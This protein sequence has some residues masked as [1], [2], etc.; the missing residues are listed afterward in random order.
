MSK[1]EMTLYEA[2]AKKKILESKV[3]KLRNY[4][5]VTEKKKADNTMIDGVPIE[6]VTEDIKGGYASTVAIMNNYI[7]LKAAINDANARTMVTIAG[8]EYSIANAIARHR[9]LYDEERMY[10]VIINDYVN[11]EKN[12]KD[13]NDRN[14]SPDAIST[15]IS[16][17]L[18]DSSKKNADVIEQM[19]KTYRDANELEIYDPLNIKELAEARLEEIEKFKEEIHY[20]LTQVNCSTK[21][22]VE[23]ED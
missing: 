21:I 5:L 10:K 15:Y 8:K 4:R 7:T 14:L 1:V 19:E 3:D 12:I 2:L 11:V 20:T 6:E 23:F 17:V 22:E 9:G 16:R 13:K 18:G